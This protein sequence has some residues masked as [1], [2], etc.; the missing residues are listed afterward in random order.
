VGFA[1]ANVAIRNCISAN[2]VIG[3]R[4][5]GG[6]AGIAFTV[7]SCNVGRITIRTTSVTSDTFY[8]AAGVCGNTDEPALISNNKVSAI[9]ISNLNNRNVYTNRKKVARVFSNPSNEDYTDVPSLQSNCCS[10]SVLLTGDISNT[11][12]GVCKLNNQIFS[13]MDTPSSS[14]HYTK[15]IGARKKNGADCSSDSDFTGYSTIFHPQNGDPTIYNFTDGSN[16]LVYPPEPTAPDGTTF[17]GWFTSPTEDTPAPADGSVITGNLTLFAHYTCDDG[18]TFDYTNQEC[19]TPVRVTVDSQNG[20]PT[21]N[22]YTTDKEGH[23]SLP[24]TPLQKPAGASAFR[25]WFTQKTGGDKVTADTKFTA[26][27]TIYAQWTCPTGQILNTSAPYECYEPSYVVLNKPDGDGGYDTEDLVTNPYGKLPTEPPAPPAPDPGATFA[28]WWSAETGGSRWTADTVYPDGT[29]LWPQWNC[30]AGKIYNVTTQACDLLPTGTC[31]VLFVNPPGISAD[32]TPPPK[33][34]ICGA[35]Y[36][37]LRPS[38]EPSSPYH[39]FDGWFTDPEGGDE[40]EF[41][42]TDTITGNLT[43]YSHWKCG[44][45]FADIGNNECEFKPGTCGEGWT[46][47]YDQSHC[48]AQIIVNTPDGGSTIIK[49]EPGQ[50]I[51]P[52]DI[53]KYPGAYDCNWYL[54]GEQS[55]FDFNTPITGPIELELRCSCDIG[56]GSNGA[57]GCTFT[58]NCPSGYHSDG[59][60]CQIIVEIIYPNG[61]PP[62]YEYIDIGS[63]FTFPQGPDITHGT[64]MGWSVQ[65]LTGALA[66]PLADNSDLKQPGQ[67]MKINYP[68]M[69]I[70]VFQGKPGWDCSD[71]SKGCVFTGKCPDCYELNEAGDDCVSDGTCGG[72]GGGGG[73]GGGSITLPQNIVNALG[74]VMDSIGNMENA[75]GDLLGSYKLMFDKSLTFSKNPETDMVET[76]HMV[77][78]MVEALSELESSLSSKLCCSVKVLSACGCAETR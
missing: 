36:R 56:F 1:G 35:T 17:G 77:E 39:T 66:E 72:G 43:L 74:N 63:D 13:D 25:G 44:K 57:G 30:G 11:V 5:V 58:G 78:R 76:S 75:A 68:M 48:V 19:F 20:Q 24:A 40:W 16:K 47:S 15:F 55:P 54:K 37:P 52:P 18:G 29:E 49:G 42:P 62:E 3:G 26:R 60:K 21:S 10:P 31:E 70:P 59:T 69:I 9:T 23:I 14:I 71:I 7:S 73:N 28:G 46:D 27:T 6:I 61:K 53:P 32:Q 33:T 64:F 4:F 2:D 51:S 41:K 22:I 12:S 8:S 38:S 34:F 67:T 45:G 50:P 65:P